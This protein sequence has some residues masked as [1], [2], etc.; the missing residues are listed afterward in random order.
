VMVTIIICYR[1]G[2]KLA[3]FN[4]ESYNLI[5]NLNCLCSPDA[6]SEKRSSSSAVSGVEADEFSGS[7]IE[8]STLT[9]M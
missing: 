1:E 9:I 4:I 2:N 8:N 5:E 7:F 6:P 3:D